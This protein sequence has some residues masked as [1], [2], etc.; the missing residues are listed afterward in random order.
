MNSV[1]SNSTNPFQNKILGFSFIMK[2][3]AK[4]I[5]EEKSIILMYL[6]FFQIIATCLHS[7]SG[8]GA[9]YSNEINT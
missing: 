6:M 8:K 9:I 2:T 7:H 1:F 3:G 4:K 5:E